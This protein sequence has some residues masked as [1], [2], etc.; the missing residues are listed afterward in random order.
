MVLGDARDG[1]APSYTNHLPIYLF[2]RTQIRDQ[3]AD[4]GHRQERGERWHGRDVVR[5]AFGD[6]VLFELAPVA[7]G[8]ELAV[9]L[10]DVAA[11]LLTTRGQLVC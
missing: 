3:V 6:L 2:E 4:L 9:V 7:Q 5:C 11:V 10:N 8:D 1:L